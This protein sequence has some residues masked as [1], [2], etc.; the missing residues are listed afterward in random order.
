M[1]IRHVSLAAALVLA[2][3]APAQAAESPFYFR[4]LAGLM[5]PSASGLKDTFNVGAGIGFQVFD[6][7]NGT[8][9][10]EVD[11]T[12]SLIKGDKEGGGDWN[13]DTA[14][15]YFAWRT[16]G[17]VYF[18]AKGG[19]ADQ[20]IRSTDNLPKGSA[21]SGGF[22]GGWNATRKAGVEVEMT[23]FDHV[24][25]VSLGVFSHF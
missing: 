1:K 10:L 18:K 21:L 19:F 22:G 15:V 7:P 13:L 16:A 11:A 6:L 17:D 23:F 2:T 9:A 20:D 5:D 3:A 12:T 24:Q 4:L 8:G 25:F 14:A